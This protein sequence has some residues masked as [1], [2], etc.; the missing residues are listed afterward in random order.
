[1][2][3]SLQ[4]MVAR[5]LVADPRR[6][7]GKVG[8]NGKAFYIGDRYEGTAP[9]EGKLYLQIVPSPWNNA[10]AGSYRVRIQTDLAAVASK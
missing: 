7:I 2:P 8:E 10:S 1:M 6:L 9:E 3:G 4:Q 5:F